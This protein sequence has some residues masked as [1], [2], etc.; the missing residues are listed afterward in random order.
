MQECLKK[1]GKVQSSEGALDRFDLDLIG[2][3]G[4]TLLA[5][6]GPW[7]GQLPA[8]YLPKQASEFALARAFRAFWAASLFAAFPSHVTIQVLCKALP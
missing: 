3:A 2:P 7:L 5:S 6:S 1:F 8:L 4:C